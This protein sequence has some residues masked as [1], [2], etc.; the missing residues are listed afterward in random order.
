MRFS[1]KD[2]FSRGD[3]SADPGF[4]DFSKGDAGFDDS[5]NTKFDNSTVTADDTGFDNT[6]DT[7][8]D[9]PTTINDSKSFDLMI[10]ETVDPTAD[11]PYDTNI[12]DGTDNAEEDVDTTGDGATTTSDNI[13][14]DDSTAIDSATVDDPATT[15]FTTV[16]D[17][18]ATAS[19]S[20]ADA[21]AIDD[22]EAHSTGSS[23]TPAAGAC[24]PTISS[25]TVNL[26]KQ[27]EGFVASPEPDPTGFPTVGFCHKLPESQL[28]RSPLFLPPLPRHHRP[29]S[30]NRRND[31]H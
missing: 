14:A 9:G 12:A 8:L 21:S 6:R 18:T 1:D 30:P 19:G 10:V 4:D 13:A 25:A 27:F 17:A 16:D 11:T 5:G 29:A 31:I 2:D 15:N 24:P 26:I 23:S 22:S 7:R 28:R 20:S 3:D